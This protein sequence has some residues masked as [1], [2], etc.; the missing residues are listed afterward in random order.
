MKCSGGDRCRAIF[1][2]QGEERSLNGDSSLVAWW[3]K[4]SWRTLGSTFIRLHAHQTAPNLCAIHIF[5]SFKHS[6]L[7]RR[8]TVVKITCNGPYPSTWSF[9]P[10]HSMPFKPHYR[11]LLQSC[12]KLELSR[13]YILDHV[14]ICCW[15]SKLAHR[16]QCSRVE[17]TLEG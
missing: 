1:D 7:M 3:T 11:V 13:K 9:V 16:P 5:V 10:T 2:V 15:C 8:E 14:Q 12:F 17:T 6:R 4:L